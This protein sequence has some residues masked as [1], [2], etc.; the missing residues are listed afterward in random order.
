MYYNCEKFVKKETALKQLP[1]DQL[2]RSRYQP[3]EVF[4]PVL[5]EELAQSIRSNGLIQP[6]VVRP[7]A[8]NAYEIIA[9]ERRWRDYANPNNAKLPKNA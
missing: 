5:L 1:V 8:T 9:G 4:D 6:L 7:I 3:R 2:K